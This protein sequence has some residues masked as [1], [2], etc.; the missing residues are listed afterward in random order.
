MPEF[1]ALLSASSSHRWL[2]CTPS[3][4]LEEKCPDEHSAY[5][6][7][8]TRAHALA[9]KRL[10]HFLDT[11]ALYKRRLKDVDA[12]MWEATGR[13]VDVCVEKI[14][15][16]Q[17]VSPDADVF[18]EKRL[19]YS[20]WVPD[21]FGTG[22]MVIYSDDCIEVVDLKYG[23][24]VPVSALGNTQM[25]LYALGALDAY[26]YL[27]DADKVR[28]SIV[29][30]RLDAISTDEI[31]TQE[32]LTWAQ[33]V[34]VPAARL[35][36]EGE[37]EK[38]A[39]AHCRFCKCRATC[40]TLAEYELHGV[41]ED[42]AASDLTEAEIADIIQRAGHI[43]KWLTD[44][45]E[46]ALQAAKD[47]KAWPGLKMVAGRSIRRIA[48]PERAAAI[49]ESH[50]I[51]DIY[52]PQELKTLTALDKLVGAKKLAELL[53]D[54]IIKPAGKPTLVPE[55]DKRPTIVPDTEAFDDSLIAE[56]QRKAV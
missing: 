28:M 49:L 22:D 13:Y 44:I 26:G 41:K 53:G 24:G 39:G 47:G 20:R 23:K 18:V 17:H 56:T 34:V 32:L 30:P 33:D 21:G 40:R 36:Y 52:K 14:K 42:L 4:R 55:S 15:E 54:V 45:E 2:V 8:G 6:A 29:Q 10:L 37:G 43:K 12:E 27:Y 7:E 25:R 1:H 50:H 31:S 5:A 46:Y 9:E 48:D 16:A 19:D 38:K 51:Q 11:G 3:A 35:A